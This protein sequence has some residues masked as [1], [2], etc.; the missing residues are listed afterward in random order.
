MQKCKTLRFCRVRSTELPL[1]SLVRYPLS[2]SFA[3]SLCMKSNNCV[4][5]ILGSREQKYIIRPRLEP[6]RFLSDLL[7][8][9]LVLPLLVF[10]TEDA[11]F[12]SRI[13]SRSTFVNR[14][15][16]VGCRHNFSI[17]FKRRA[18]LCR[19][20]PLTSFLRPDRSCKS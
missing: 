14:Q 13:L 2:H 12:S 18:S 16:L 5:K 3:A 20:I 9:L 10:N 19:T 15:R 17:I 4:A 8:S 1:V 11:I 7:A 6:D